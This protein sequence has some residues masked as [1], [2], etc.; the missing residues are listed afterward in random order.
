[1]PY[2]FEAPVG[3]AVE[4]NAGKIWPAEW[5]DANPY[6][7]KK[8]YQVRPGSWAYHTGADLNMRNNQ[9]ENAP[10]Y[11]MGAGSVTYA[12]VFPKKGVWGGIIIIYHGTVD[13]L[14]KGIAVRK[15]VYSRYAHVNGIAVSAGAT[16]AKG[17]QIARIG[18]RELGFDP[19]LHFD[20]STTSILRKDAGFWPGRNVELVKENFVDP[21]V[22][23]YS[24]IK[25]STASIHTP[26]EQDNTPGTSAGL[27][28]ADFEGEQV[29]EKHSVSAKVAFVLNRGAEM[30]LMKSAKKQDGYVWGQISG[31]PFKEHWVRVS[32]DDESVFYFRNQ[33][34]AS[35]AS[36]DSV[37]IRYAQFDKS[38]VREDHSTSSKVV[39]EL[40]KG[41]ELVLLK[42]GR[43]HDGFFW[44]MIS[45]G[46]FNGYWVAVCKDDVSA[47]YF[48]AHRPA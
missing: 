26:L 13:F 30:K 34:P 36:A 35:G 20:I 43:K 22:W 33:K 12:R 42:Q 8:M 11:A 10:V 37:E 21:M 46:I 40:K 24:H 31:G 44:G 39:Y 1:M 16:V 23:L 3:P 19:H 17:Q 7:L 29:Y 2:L 41:A 6:N 48:T 47:F 27:W 4:R 28:Y 15:V 9:D 25:N 5:V 38:E 32:K 14:E 45:G 18:G